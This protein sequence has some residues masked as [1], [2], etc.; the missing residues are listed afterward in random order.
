[1]K[2][3]QICLPVSKVNRHVLLKMEKTLLG[4]HADRITALDLPWIIRQTAGVGTT[5]KSWLQ[6]EAWWQAFAWGLIQ[7][8]LCNK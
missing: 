5:K 6:T 7:F 1:M 3:K 2:P 4:V 8:K